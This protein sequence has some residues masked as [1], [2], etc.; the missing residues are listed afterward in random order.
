MFEFESPYYFILVLLLPIGLVAQKAYV[1][2]QTEKQ[3]V[4]SEPKALEKLLVNSP[5]QISRIKFMLQIMAVFF[6]VLA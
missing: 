5:K 4:F 1:K 2:W 6:I 3:A